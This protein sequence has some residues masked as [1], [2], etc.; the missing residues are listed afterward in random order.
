MATFK[1]K[2]VQLALAYAWRR[3]YDDE[4]EGMIT[5]RLL[6]NQQ[7]LIVAE[8]KRYRDNVGWIFS[9]SYFEIKNKSLK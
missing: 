3:Y 4:L 6:E 5:L 1:A 8:R 7:E 9:N 2:S